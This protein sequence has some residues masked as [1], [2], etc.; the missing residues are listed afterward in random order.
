V[1]VR[2]SFDATEFKEI[3]AKLETTKDIGAVTMAPT[4]APTLAPTF[5]GFKV[6]EKQI[7]TKAILARLKFSLTVEEARNHVMQHSMIG[8]FSGAMGLP[9]QYVEIL[10]VTE[11]GRRLQGGSGV[12]GNGADVE[13]KITSPDPADIAQ[14]EKDVKQ[15]AA[16]GAVVANIIQK[17]AD[18]AVLTP[19]LRDMGIN[20]DVQTSVVATQ[21][22][23]TE[24]VKDEDDTP[25]FDLAGVEP[26]LNQL[27]DSLTD[28]GK[29]GIASA[30]LL[31]VF[32]VVPVVRFCST[33]SSSLGPP[34]QQPAALGNSLPE[35][36]AVRYGNTE[37]ALNAARGIQ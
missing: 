6:V 9:L 7:K 37:G 8:G 28:A 30:V 21:T 20:V 1:R 14:L 10:G 11:P 13:F 34:G 35:T 18:N 22:T 24:V 36:P 12:T 3:L 17:A 29:A 27:G 2:A 4:K 31:V 23:V 19:S 5:A 15:G 32:I 26:I 33:S 16:E 25:G